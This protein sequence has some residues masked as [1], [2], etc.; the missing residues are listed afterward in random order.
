[1]AYYH[2]V[3]KKKLYRS[4]KH[5]TSNY[6]TWEQKIHAKEYLLYPENI[7]AYLS[8]DEVS[9]SKGE[10][11]T[12]I[13]SKAGKGKKGTIVAMIASTESVKIIEV[14][15]KIQ[16]S[17]RLEVKEITLDMAGNMASAA[18][19]SFPNAS[20][21][22]D[23]FHVVKLVLE[24][25]QHVRIKYR[26]E[27][28]DK[29]NEAIKEAKKKGEKYQPEVFA[30]GDM[31]KQ[32]LTRSRYL[33]FKH[34]TDWTITQQQRAAILF[35]KYPLLK[36][37]HQYATQF[38][39]IYENNNV[40]NAKKQFMQWIDKI[41]KQTE[42]TQFNSAAKSIEYHLENILNFFTN[43]NTNA[44]AESFNS[45]IK[46]FRANQKGVRDVVFFLFRLE[47]LFA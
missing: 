6:Q 11:Y 5:K 28:I 35:S 7:S 34:E 23:R 45:K 27:A 31:L 29:E 8:I 4:Y 1:M 37:A 38:R 24:A 39:N 10:L 20:I 22:T 41:K 3:S 47:K 33:L 44:N 30:N 42:L 2:Q 19:S 46:L 13:T 15:E 36:K 16:L 26:W 12:F 9:L 32:L 25:L 18:R 40:G 14:L 17:K 21:V 43:R